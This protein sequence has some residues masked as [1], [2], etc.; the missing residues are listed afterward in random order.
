M[1]QTQASNVWCYTWCRC[2]DECKWPHHPI[3]FPYKLYVRTQFSTTQCF[4]LCPS[5]RSLQEQNPLVYFLCCW[6]KG[7]G[8]WKWLAMWNVRNLLSLDRFV[9]PRGRFQT[10]HTITLYNHLHVLGHK[11]CQGTC[12]T[13]FDQR[14]KACMHKLHRNI[15]Q[16][17]G[18]FIRHNTYST[19]KWKN[20]IIKQC[21]SWTISEDKEMKTVHYVYEKTHD[22]FTASSSCCI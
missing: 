21:Q 11:L 10:I 13:W 9:I 18:R 17:P 12:V 7:S 1:D 5:V 4:F 2:D 20:Y 16:L 14:S 8:P 3:D 19:W 6:R 15:A 22:P